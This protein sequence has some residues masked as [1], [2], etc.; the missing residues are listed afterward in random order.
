MSGAL[1]LRAQLHVDMAT[2][3]GIE[4]A[5]TQ[6]PRWVVNNVQERLRNKLCVLHISAQ[7]I[8]FSLFKIHKLN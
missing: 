4:R 5:Q 8:V 2:K 1:G 6:Y 3:V 7:V